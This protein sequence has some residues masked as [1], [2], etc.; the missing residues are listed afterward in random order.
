MAE[1]AVKSNSTVEVPIGSIAPGRCGKFI[2]RAE[3]VD[4]DSGVVRDV[5]VF[6]FA[7]IEHLSRRGTGDGVTVCGQG[8]A[9]DMG[10]RR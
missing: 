6:D 3:L 4:K 2:F 10:G 1:V 9:V 7:T 5:A 8:A